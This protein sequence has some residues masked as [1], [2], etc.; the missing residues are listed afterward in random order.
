MSGNSYL[1]SFRAKNASTFNLAPR[2][3]QE[4]SQIN[5][6][7]FSRLAVCATH[8]PMPNPRPFWK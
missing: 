5:Q 7:R 6:R 8:R 4:L 2:H 1:Q 3:D